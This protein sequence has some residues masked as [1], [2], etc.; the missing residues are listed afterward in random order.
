[1]RSRRMAEKEGPVS[2]ERGCWDA[3]PTCANQ[4]GRI[5]RGRA[6]VRKSGGD[7]EASPDLD[8]G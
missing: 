4:V 1:M 7:H 3:G 6:L 5:R 2:F 8:P